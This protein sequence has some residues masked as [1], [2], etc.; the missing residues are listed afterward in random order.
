MSF[1]YF[2]TSSSSCVCFLRLFL[3]FSSSFLRL[4][5]AFSSS[6]LS[7]LFA[8][9]L[10]LSFVAF[11]HIFLFHIFLFH[12]LSFISSSSSFQFIWHIKVLHILS[13]TQTPLSPSSDH[14]HLSP[15]NGACNHCSSITIKLCWHL[16]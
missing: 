7:F 10:Y 6:F 3:A 2:M 16:L 5:F 15:E 12:I 1:L 8:F 13:S 14:I 4:F 11:F 9:Y